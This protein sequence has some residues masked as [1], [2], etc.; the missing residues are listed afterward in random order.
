MSYIEKTEYGNVL[1]LEESWSKR[2]DILIQKDEVIGVYLNYA[3]G[4]GDR[5]IDFLRK[6]KDLLYVR[7]VS[8]QLDDISV[9][10]EMDKLKYIRLD[11]KIIKEIDLDN[12][13]ELREL[14]ISWTNKIENLEK[15]QSLRKLFLYKYKKRD[16]EELASLSNL[17]S[18]HISICP[19]VS[20][21]DLKTLNKL[22]ELELA[23]FSKLDSLSGLEGAKELKIL[24]IDT[25]KKIKKLNSIKELKKIKSLSINNLGDIES[26][27]PIKNMKNLEE[28]FF[29]E[30]TNILDGNLSVLLELPKLKKISFQNRKNY[31][32][33]REEI[34]ELL[35]QPS[36]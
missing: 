5:A 29:W 23:R 14:G 32:H 33:T 20:I 12:F 13:P 18:L 7:I 6:Y 36:P 3:N 16:L 1:V 2:H 35:N 28:L 10:N 31:S 27:E 19:A 17:L 8:P 21:I 22:Q 15:A 26:L 24:S 30:S 9:L 4:W 11:V 34:H 25:C